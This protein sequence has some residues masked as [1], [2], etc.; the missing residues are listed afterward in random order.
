MTSEN[1]NSGGQL[2]L[3]VAI[4]DAEPVSDWVR[5]ALQKEPVEIAKPYATEALLEIYFDSAL[6]AEIA[7]KA[8]PE[9]LPVKHAAV[10]EYQ[11]QDWTTFWRH[12]FQTLE[13][14]GWKSADSESSLSGRKFQTLEKSTSSSTPG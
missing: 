13:I 12:H 6:E 3:L 9:D 8:L 5:E 10:R 7:R 14:G 1:K 11:E 2:N 4:T